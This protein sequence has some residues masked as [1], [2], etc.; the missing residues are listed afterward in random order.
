[1]LSFNIIHYSKVNWNWHTN[2]K[3]DQTGPFTVFCSLVLRIVEP[4]VNWKRK[5]QF[6]YDGMS[7]LKLNGYTTVIIHYI[8]KMTDFK[9][10]D[11]SLKKKKKKNQ[12]QKIQTWAWNWTGISTWAWLMIERKNCF[13]YHISKSLFDI[14]HHY[15][16]N[17]SN[18]YNL[19][20]SE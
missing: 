1:M 12:Q 2:S 7:K 19:W 11:L 3:H 16:S 5:Q 4:L 9:R 18:I 14:R 20:N 17:T 13:K 10:S 15:K 6:I 8:T